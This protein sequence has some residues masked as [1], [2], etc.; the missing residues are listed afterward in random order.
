MD[1]G[2]IPDGGPIITLTSRQE[3]EV[4]IEIQN[5]PVG[6]ILRHDV[7]DGTFAEKGGRG[8]LSYLDSA[9]TALPDEA[10]PRNKDSAAYEFT[11]EQSMYVWSLVAGAVS[12]VAHLRKPITSND[13]L[14]SK[15]NDQIND[16]VNNASN[17]Q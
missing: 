8:I 12:R 10:E 9:Q 2:R 5:S 6:D 11:Y 16:A 3:A 15:L 13:A 17:T 14:V 7:S 4:L 1:I